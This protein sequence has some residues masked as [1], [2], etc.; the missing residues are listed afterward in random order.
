MTYPK[1]LL[2]LLGPED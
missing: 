2:G 1:I